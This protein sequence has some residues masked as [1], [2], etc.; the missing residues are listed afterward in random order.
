MRSDAILHAT[1]PL[2]ALVLLGMTQG[3]KMQRLLRPMRA[4]VLVAL[5][6]ACAAFLLLRA[7]PAPL[8]PF[9]LASMCFL[10]GWLVLRESVELSGDSGGEPSVLSP[11]AGAAAA[12]AVG[13]SAA[14][15]ALLSRAPAAWLGMLEPP[16]GHT[17]IYA[18][19]ALGGL[20]VRCAL[21]GTTF[22]HVALAAC[23]WLSVA[24]VLA[25]P[26]GPFLPAMLLLFL[27]P[28]AIGA[29][30]RRNPAPHV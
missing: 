13:A 23:A 4:V 29:T 25:A 6:C 19:C 21:A 30:W 8:E 18:L 7:R 3:P 2:L 5:A 27:A 28:A 20:F 16:L 24:E 1:I 10:A 12:V 11:L 9:S 14:T 17:T 22:L 26:G 15:L